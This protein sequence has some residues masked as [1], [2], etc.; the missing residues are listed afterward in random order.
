MSGTVDQTA[1][2][3]FTDRLS[4]FSVRHEMVTAAAVS[5]RLDDIVT[6]PAVGVP[7]PDGSGDLPASVETDPSPDD[8]RRA[9]TGVTPAAMGVASYGSLVLPMD[10]EETEPVSLF[11]DQHVAVVRT[12]E[13]V[14]GMADAIERLGDRIRD[15]R[16][17][18][19]LA[20]GPSATA[21]MGALVEG[22]HGPKTVYALLVEP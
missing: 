22:A 7:L 15:R 14:P 10:R 2:N 18:A 19:I 16:S 6:R 3:R 11:A 12:D 5:D 20:T 4:D 17:S 8:L 1:V 21:D 13:I 9:E